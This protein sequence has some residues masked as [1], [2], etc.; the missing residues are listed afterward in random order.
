MITFNNV[1]FEFAGNFLYEDLYWNISNGQ[2]IGLIGKNGTGKSTLL[3][4]ITGE[5]TA[6][7]GQIVREKNLNIGFLNQDMLSFSFELPLFQ[8]V[9]MAFKNLQ[10]LKQDIDDLLTRLDNGDYSEELLTELSDKQND[11]LIQ[12]GYEMDARTYEVLNGLGFEEKELY[13]PYNKFS[14]G[15][16]MRAM[17]AQ[18]LL[19]NPDLLL[20]DEPTNHLDLPTIKWLEGYVNNISASYIVVSHDRHFLDKM[21]REIVEISNRKLNFYT[22][23]YSKYLV[24]KA[25]RYEIEKAAYENQ[26]K[27]IQD[28]ERFIERFKAKASKATQAQSRVKM[29][30]KLERL[31]PPEE[32]SALMNLRFKISNQPGQDV[33]TID[34]VTK[35][36]KEK[37]VFDKATQV[38]RRGAKIGLIGPNGV[39]KTTLLKMI[40]G[41]L[42]LDTGNI[43]LGYN[44]NLTYFA[45][46]QL[47]SLTLDYTIIEELRNHAPDWSETQIRTLLGC[48]LF[49]G[50]TVNKKI[51]ILSGGEK[52]RVALAKTLVNQS[53]FM[54][55][56]E[57]TNHLDIQS[58][59]ML[60]DA[61]KNY[62]GTFIVV[63][64]DRYFLEQI[65]NTIWYIENH[66][67]REYPGTYAEF[68][69]WCSRQQV[70]SVH[71]NSDSGSRNAVS[72]NKQNSPKNE[73]VIVKPTDSKNLKQVEKQIQ[74]LELKKH[75]TEKKLTLESWD[76]NS[77]SYKKVSY[78]YNE[79]QKQLDEA[80]AIWETLV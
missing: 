3:R 58:I 5:Y 43:Q 18:I 28:T 80:V 67:I 54:I 22:G 65:A 52:S 61:L 14:G 57:P 30:D 24:Q 64:H 60:I 27:E 75:E 69:E 68:D 7:E 77:T 55:L 2:Q 78:E 73:P 13:K 71:N 47:E 32:D 6:T 10:K 23:N 56:D 62:E 46:H 8:V 11:F 33:V 36:F 39:G 21:V 74:E 4:L 72:D 59:E 51:K 19:S 38:I 9:Q 26:Q 76:T 66:Q 34:T 41:D 49:T 44:V 12:G 17:L 48:M 70:L 1:S 29:L 50:D 25:E 16:R 20:L 31:S 15:W 79:I 35:S 45:Q 40:S 37:I 42:P 53:N 63:S